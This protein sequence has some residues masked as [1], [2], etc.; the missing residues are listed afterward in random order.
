MASYGDQG[1]HNTGQKRLAPSR[2]ADRQR[3]PCDAYNLDA[4]VAFFRCI[5]WFQSPC[6][7][8]VSHFQGYSRLRC[9]RNPM[10]LT[11]P[12][13]PLDQK[14]TAAQR[15]I[16]GNGHPY[17]TWLRLLSWPQ[18]SGDR[19]VLVVWSLLSLWQETADDSYAARKLQRFWDG[20]QLRKLIF[21]ASFH[22]LMSICF[23]KKRNTESP[24]VTSFSNVD[25]LQSQWSPHTDGGNSSHIQPR[26]FL[27]MPPHISRCREALNGS[28]AYR[29]WQSWTGTESRESQYLRYWTNL[30]K[31]E[32]VGEVLI[33]FGSSLDEWRPYNRIYEWYI[34]IF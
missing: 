9:Q 31:Y 18:T 29:K 2:I 19:R 7:F 23:V 27:P 4:L 25:G 8:G 26:I 16:L 22:T 21:S 20:I 5:P 10:E 28:E 13:D 12:E 1:Y 34:T 14:P 3:G 24:L 32:K 17:R 6:F 11:C 33:H 15:H 30:K